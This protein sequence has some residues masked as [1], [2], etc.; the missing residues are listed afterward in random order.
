MAEGVLD[1]EM[2][3]MFRRFGITGQ[4][5]AVLMVVFGILIIVLPALVAYL[6][7]VYLIVVGILQLMNHFESRPRTAAP[8]PAPPTS[9]PYSPPGT[10][11][12]SYP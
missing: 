3:R 12:P 8:P 10:P 2:E 11:P 9:P 6:V 7:G 5:A 4:A 1:S